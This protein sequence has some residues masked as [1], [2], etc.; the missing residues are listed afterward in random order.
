[1]NPLTPRKYTVLN[2]NIVFNLHDV[3]QESNS[4]VKQDLPVRCTEIHTHTHTLQVYMPTSDIVI[5][6]IG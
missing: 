2:R 5:H 3:F 6:Y 1:V 4:G